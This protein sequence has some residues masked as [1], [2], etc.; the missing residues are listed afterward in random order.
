MRKNYIIA[1]IIII[2][3]GI[4]VINSKTEP[5]TNAEAI[6]IGA[7][8][9]MSGTGG[10]YGECQYNGAVLAV[11]EF[12]SSIS[13]K[14]KKVELIL[15]DTKGETKDGLNAY[16]NIKK[17]VQSTIVAMSGIVLSVGPLA[18][19]DKIVAMN[20]G[21]K[22]P[23]ISN[24]GDYVFSTV[25]NSDFD[26]KVFAK[27][28]KNKLNINNV[29]LISINNDYGMGTSNAFLNS[30]TA[31][32]G[33]IVANE[34][35]D[36]SATDFRT[37]LSKIK[38]SKPEGIFIIGYKEQ[39]LLLKQAGDLGIKTQWLAPEPFASPDIIGLAGVSADGVIYHIPN[40]D[41]QTNEEPA[42]SFFANYKK[43]FGKEADFCSANSYD[44]VKLLTKAISSV[45]NDGE[46]IKNWLYNEKNWESTTGKSTFD[47]NG[48][49]TK[50][51]MI[52][53]VKDGKFVKYNQ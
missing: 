34:K 2:L 6:K 10:I 50:D 29:A 52:M 8:L 25:Q 49:V 11:E 5:S 38:V 3:I 33:K 39:G 12:N 46:K 31:E 36:A 4:V 23:K 32:G 22:N 19:E 18:D 42:K 21:A 45:G 51:L 35:Y 47:S 48:D 27:F 26:E 13:A 17:D 43:R 16:S 40:L 41:P 1:V 7:L 20:I 44:A 9:P 15:Q 24:A 53:T 28:V 37:I 30:F 14:D